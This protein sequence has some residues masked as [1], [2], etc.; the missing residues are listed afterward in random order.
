[1]TPVALNAIA[2][3]IF[4][5]SA[6]VL[7]GPL[8]HLPPEWPASM[9]LGVLS[10]AAVDT[11][12]FERRGT[13]LLLDW[14]AQ[15]SSQYRQRLVHHEAGHFLVA[16]LLDLPVT[17]YTL[18]AWEA[19]RQGHSGQG[20]VQVDVPEL[21]GGAT[22]TPLLERCCAVWMAG[23]VAEALVYDTV[24]GGRDDRQQLRRT[25]AQLNMD[26]PLQERQAEQRARQLLRDN[27]A[28]YEALVV[29]MA[30]RESVAD[31][32]ELIDL[33]CHK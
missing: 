10:I 22:V 18:S 21:E 4:L 11:F 23:S 5:M 29:A 31:C 12:G 27:W 7:L 15:T 32:C 16:H 24:E 26:V 13:T 6:S 14:F 17:E 9:T 28:A 33:H 2:I 3:F 25:L 1:M 19:L 20:G 30:Q 8:I